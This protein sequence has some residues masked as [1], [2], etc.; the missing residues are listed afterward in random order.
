[1]AQSGQSD[2]P[3]RGGAAVGRFGG[4]GGPG[5]P[6][7]QLNL[8]DAQKQQ[9]QD[10]QSRH[11]DEDRQIAARLRTALDAQR[12]A[13]EAEPLNDGAIRTASQQL[14]DVEADAAVARAHLRSEI[15]A[16]LTA[17]QKAQLSQLE[18]RQG[19]RPQGRGVRP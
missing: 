17:D 9:V 3:R 8:T 6:L 19:K 13:I 18:T 11:R 1:V 4:P 10:I 16:V 2:G 7:R 14:A 15:L 5:L 12:K